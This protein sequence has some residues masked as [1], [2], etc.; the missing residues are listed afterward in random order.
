MKPPQSIRCH[1]LLARPRRP[2]R[3]CQPLATTRGQLAAGCAR[4]T[5]WKPASALEVLSALGLAAVAAV[6]HELAVPC[7]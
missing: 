5:C 7:G 6:R 2:F 3:P 1:D 4:R